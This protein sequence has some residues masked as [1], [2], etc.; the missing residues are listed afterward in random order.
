L[1]AGRDALLARKPSEKPTNVPVNDQTAPGKADP[2]ASTDAVNQLLTA[3]QINP[4]YRAKLGL[5]VHS[6]CHSLWIVVEDGRRLWYELQV[7]DESNSR[8]PRTDSYAW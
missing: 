7:L 8:Q 6:S 4:K 1:I 3:A 5:T 2:T